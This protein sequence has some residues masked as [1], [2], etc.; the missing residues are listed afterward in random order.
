MSVIR[1][2]RSCAAVARGRQ[3][4]LLRLAHTK[5][6]TVS[7]SF[8]LFLSH[9]AVGEARHA[10]ERE[11]DEEDSSETFCARWRLLFFFF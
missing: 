2:S 4:L 5:R 1:S 9:A 8:S 6:E 3:L 10:G 7:L 11:E